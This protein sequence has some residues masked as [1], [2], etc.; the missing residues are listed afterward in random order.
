[1][2]NSINKVT[3][4]GIITEMSELKKTPDGANC[5]FTLYVDDRYEKFSINVFCR[6]YGAELTADEFK[7]NDHIAVFGRLYTKDNSLNVL[8]SAVVSDNNTVVPHYYPKDY[9]VKQ[10]DDMARQEEISRIAEESADPEND[11]F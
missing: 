4:S 5:T 3:L 10:R 9:A 8:A 6:G 2:N 11:P 7:V 1:M